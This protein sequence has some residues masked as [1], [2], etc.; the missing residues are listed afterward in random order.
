VPAGIFGKTGLRRVLSDPTQWGANRGYWKIFKEE[1]KLGVPVTK[2]FVLTLGINARNREEAEDLALVAGAR[3]GEIARFYAG[4]PFEPAYLTK[5][6]K[7]GPSEGVLEQYDYFYFEQ[8]GQLTR[9]YLRESAF[10]ML[11]DRLP[12]LGPEILD[13]ATLA[14]HWYNTAVTAPD[15]LDQY[16]AIWIGLESIGPVI[17][18]KFHRDGT[19]SPCETC[20]NPAGEDR[21]SMIAGIHH[22]AMARAKELL[23]QAT[24]REMEKIRHDIVHAL[25]GAQN[26]REQID[27]LLPDLLLVLASAIL[28]AFR[29]E[30][31]EVGTTGGGRWTVLGPPDHEKR[32]DGRSTISSTAELSAHKPFFGSWISVDISLSDEIAREEP[33]G[34][35]VR[36]SGVAFECFFEI[37]KGQPMPEREYVWF[38]R[39]GINF[40]DPPGVE[41]PEGQ[42]RARVVD[43]RTEQPTPGM[44]RLLEEQREIGLVP[45]SVSTTTSR[46]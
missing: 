6:A 4:S 14:V 36:G 10:E 3:F 1:D 21:D 40:E 34:L 46:S 17:S 30:S 18:K 25:N 35:Y 38:R 22:M 13:R 26:I 39:N 2:G 23:G 19:R 42:V 12:E 27:G 7:L 45:K 24:I 29:P 9:H 5:L 41:L 11:L 15:P 16:L 37:P 8:G 31:D 43:W 44:L 32:P 33:D 20:Q 28:T